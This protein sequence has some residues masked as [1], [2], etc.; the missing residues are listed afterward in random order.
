MSD[1][2]PVL[3]VILSLVSIHTARYTT[4]ILGGR[5]EDRT[6]QGTASEGDA[7]LSYRDPGPFST[8]QVI[9][10]VVLYTERFVY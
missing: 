7:S 1:S 10:T 3:A 8:V 9:P 2:F 5:R 4:R 6:R